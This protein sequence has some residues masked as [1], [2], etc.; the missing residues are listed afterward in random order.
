[1]NVNSVYPDEAAH[2]EP[3][4]LAIYY[5]IESPICNYGHAKSQGW[6]SLV[7]KPRGELFKIK[8]IS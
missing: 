7:Q 5:W 6:K 2:N 1:M 3:S 8:Y 4:N